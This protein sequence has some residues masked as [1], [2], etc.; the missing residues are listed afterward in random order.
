MH[1]PPPLFFRLIS[2]WNRISVS[3]SL[4]I[5]I[6]SFLQA[7]YALD[8]SSCN[9]PDLRSA[10]MEG[11]ACRGV[12][13]TCCSKRMIFLKLRDHHCTEL[14]PVDTVNDRRVVTELVERAFGIAHSST[15][16]PRRLWVVKISSDEE[17]IVY[18]AGR[19]T[20]SPQLSREPSSLKRALNIVNL[21]RGTTDSALQ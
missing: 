3:G 16:V 4:R 19:G 1:P 13:L 18:A 14:L 10:N 7:H 12:E 17:S 8:N 11:C 2:R 21:L 5:G 6:A 9:K 20:L 15:G